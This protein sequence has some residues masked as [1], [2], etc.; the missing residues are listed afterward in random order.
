MKGG[1]KTSNEGGVEGSVI[2]GVITTKSGGVKGGVITVQ[3]AGVTVV[4]SEK[5]SELIKLLIKDNQL[6][7]NQLAKLWNINYSAA[8]KHFIALKTKGAIRRMG[9]DKGGFWEVLIKI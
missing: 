2:G 8:Q 6:S 5:Q 4:L 9:P 1:V 3:I 7:F